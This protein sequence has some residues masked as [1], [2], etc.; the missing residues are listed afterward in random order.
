VREPPRPGEH[1]AAV[2]AD[3]AARRGAKQGG[4]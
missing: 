3:L 2:M 4:A 1:T